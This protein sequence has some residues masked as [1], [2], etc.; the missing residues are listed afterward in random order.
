MLATQNHTVDEWWKMK[1]TKDAIGLLAVTVGITTRGACQELMNELE[2]TRNRFMHIMWREYTRANNQ[3]TSPAYQAHYNAA[4]DKWEQVRLEVG[5]TRNHR[6]QTMPAKV[7]VENERWTLSK[8]GRELES[9]K[10]VRNSMRKRR[11]IGQRTIWEWVQHGHSRYARRE[12][13]DAAGATRAQR[14]GNDADVTSDGACPAAT[15]AGIPA[16]QIA[17]SRRAQ[18]P[19]NTKQ[20]KITAW[21]R[22]TGATGEGGARKKTRTRQESSDAEMSGN[23]QGPGASGGLQHG[24]ARPA[25]ISEQGASGGATPYHDLEDQ[26]EGREGADADTDAITGEKRRP[27]RRSQG[28]DERRRRVE[29]ERREDTGATGREPDRYG[30]GR[31]DDPG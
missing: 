17:G 14:R 25:Q 29:G 7:T 19:Q 2:R 6:R 27:G 22:P 9:W 24:A 1:W 10:R 18:R 30:D 26:A 12:E 13:D 15:T 28:R 8:L 31:A 3:E 20:G 4:L 21:Y 23:G 16:R 5:G 11:G